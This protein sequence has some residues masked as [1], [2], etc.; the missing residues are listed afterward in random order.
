MF[1]HLLEYVMTLGAG[2]YPYVESRVSANPTQSR[3]SIFQLRPK[4]D[5]IAV[6][7]LEDLAADTPQAPSLTWR[8]YFT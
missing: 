4:L 7:G 1:V 6:V 5:W 3:R 2:H 8:V